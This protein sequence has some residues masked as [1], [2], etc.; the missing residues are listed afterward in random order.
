MVHIYSLGIKLSTIFENVN[1]IFTFKN[2]ICIVLAT[3]LDIINNKR[4]VYAL[5]SGDKL[6]RK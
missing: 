1:I 6:G 4:I 3:F 5:E 2:K